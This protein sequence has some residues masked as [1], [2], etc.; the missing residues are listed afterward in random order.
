[1]EPDRRLPNDDEMIVMGNREPMERDDLPI[2]DQES[3]R[4]KFYKRRVLL[5]R[6]GLVLAIIV[7]I[8][9]FILTTVFVVKGLQS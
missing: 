8:I 9:V 6:L 1:M 5:K 3:L 4:F 2:V 7:L